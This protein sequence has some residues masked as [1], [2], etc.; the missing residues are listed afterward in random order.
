[1]RTQLSK[2]PVGDRRDRRRVRRR[3]RF[4]RS[5]LRRKTG[6]R[7]RIHNGQQ[8]DG[9]FLH[10]PCLGGLYCM[11]PTRA[12]FVSL[13]LGNPLEPGQGQEFAALSG[14]DLVYAVE[15]QNHDSEFAFDVTNNL[16]NMIGRLAG[17]R[18]ASQRCSIVQS[19]APVSDRSFHNVQ[20]G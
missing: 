12:Q 16:A 1:M 17:N 9:S 10:I 5:D 3:R 2:G 6:R 19:L 7:P 15:D 14:R 11:A 8:R 18:D 4:S 13:A 20:S